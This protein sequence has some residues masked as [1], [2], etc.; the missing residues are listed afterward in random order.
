MAEEKVTIIKSVED[1]I[2]WSKSLGVGEFVYRGQ[3]DESWALR[4]GAAR[5]MYDVLKKVDFEEIK[6]YN[7]E[8]LESAMLKGFD[9]KD[10]HHLGELELLA[11]LQHHGAATPLLDFS[12]NALVALW[13]ACSEESDKDGKIYAL[14]LSETEKFNKGFF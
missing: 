5:R 4:S 13:M 10:N 11:E 7:E 8:L 9:K 6:D 1:Y 14:D 3:A 12:K 2:N